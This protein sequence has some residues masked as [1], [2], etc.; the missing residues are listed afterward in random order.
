[1]KRLLSIPVLLIV[2]SFNA[3]SC[4]EKEKAVSLDNPIEI[5]DNSTSLNEDNYKPG[6]EWEIVWSDEFKAD[7][8]DS[9]NWNFQVEEAGRF[10]DEWQR[11]TNSSNNAYIDDDCLV[12]KVIHE[13]DVHGM[14][15]YTSA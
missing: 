2:L 3:L 15:Q 12:I 8:I 5:T 14:D 9:K 1:M 4:K 13:S 11:Y 6:E 7:S 10:N